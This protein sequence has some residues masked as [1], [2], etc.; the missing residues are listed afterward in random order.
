MAKMCF[1]SWSCCH[2]LEELLDYAEKALSAPVWSVQVK[3]SRAFLNANRRLDVSQ[4][5][6]P[7]KAVDTARDLVRELTL[8]GLT[9]F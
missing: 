6:C 5:F 7:K 9:H 1:W 4:Y 3:T 2:E 8:S